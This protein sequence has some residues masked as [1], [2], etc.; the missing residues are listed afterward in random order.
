MP[1]SA[2]CNG[3]APPG[4]AVPLA[5]SHNFKCNHVV[6]ERFEF[7]AAWLEILCR[8]EVI[9][10]WLSESPV[11]A[12]LEKERG[13]MTMSYTAIFYCCA[14]FCVLRCNCGICGGEL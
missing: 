13:D 6:H 7:V 1:M 10:R 4:M 11:K 12:G 9:P 2:T 5:L 3:T 8:R 14:E